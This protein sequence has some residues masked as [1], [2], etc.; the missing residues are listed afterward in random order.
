MCLQVPA[1]I[2]HL[3]QILS[4]LRLFLARA[5]WRIITLNV[6]C[7]KHCYM[8]VK[9]HLFESGVASIS[10]ISKLKCKELVLL[11]SSDW[12]TIP[13][14][15][16]PTLLISMYALLIP[17]AVLNFPLPFALNLDIQLW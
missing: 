1:F 9:H 11:E 12:N 6:Y 3:P 13:K 16:K 10:Q 8:L 4:F 5:T 7:V 2:F 15:P 14:M 17:M